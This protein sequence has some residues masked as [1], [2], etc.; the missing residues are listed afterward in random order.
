[1]IDELRARRRRVV[2]ERLLGPAPRSSPTQHRRLRLLGRRRLE[3]FGPTR[4]PFDPSRTA[5]GSSG[6]S[7]AALYYDGIDTR[8]APTR[9]ARSA[10]P[11]PWCG[12]LGLQADAR[13]R[14]LHRDRR[15]RRDL[16]PRRPDDADRRGRRAALDVIAGEDPSDPRQGGVPVEDYVPG[17]RGGGRVDLAG[18]RDRAGGGG[19]VD[20]V[21]ARARGRGGPMQGA[22][23][24]CAI[25]AP[26][27]A[28][29]RCPEHLPR[30][31]VAFAGLHRGDDGAARRRRQRLPLAG[32]LR[33]GL[34]RRARG[35]GCARAA[36]G[37][38]RRSR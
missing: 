15:H 27:C 38:P 12:V 33:P 23:G 37:S 4:N 16:R 30:G 24:A 18:L 7:G 14:A 9:A 32:P 19:P 1:M 8:S 6:G 21:G 20:A 26:R 13:P 10:H 28:R 3:P 2:V 11:P 34:R 29:S 17:G 35:R 36:D 31:A 5:A 25:S 22:A